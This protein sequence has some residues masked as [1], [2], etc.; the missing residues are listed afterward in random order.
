MKRLILFDIDG[1]LLTTDGAAKRAFHRALLEVYGTAGPIGS[2]LFDGKTDPQIARELLREAGF[3][4]AAIDG[5]FPRF[6][7]SYL[8]ELALELNLPGHRTTVLPGVH[9][10]LEALERRSADCVLGLFPTERPD[11]FD[12]VELEGESRVVAV[13]PKPGAGPWH[14]TWLVAGWCGRFAEF[15]TE[16]MTK[17]P[18]GDLHLG[19]AIQDALKAGLDVR[20]VSIPGVS[21]RDVGTPEDLRAAMREWWA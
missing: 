21:F 16:W 19:F 18:S 13:H 4:D 7:P 8:R 20:G 11:K 5:G 9:A 12:M 6:W 17:P 3:P 10:L 1:T 2:H 15:L 14:L